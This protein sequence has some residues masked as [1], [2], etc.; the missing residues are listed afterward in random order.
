M[1][2]AYEAF[3]HCVNLSSNNVSGVCDGTTV[4]ST[5][6]GASGT[7]CYNEYQNYAYYRDLV[8]TGTAGCFFDDDV[9]RDGDGSPDDADTDGVN[10]GGIAAGCAIT[11]GQQTHAIA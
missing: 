9:D 1:A 8:W 10:D 6:W 2:T 3:S 5:C 4:T 7:P 11:S